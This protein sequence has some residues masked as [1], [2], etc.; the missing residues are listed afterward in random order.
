MSKRILSLMLVSLL[1]VGCS[2]KGGKVKLD[3]DGVAKVNGNPI[4]VSVYSGNSVENEVDGVKYTAKIITADNLSTAE[5]NSRGVATKDMDKYKDVLVF[6]EYLGSIITMYKD[7]GNKKYIWGTV[8]S[9]E[10]D[11]EVRKQT[12]YNTM[13]SSPLT[14]EKL[15]VDIG[16]K[17]KFKAAF[18]EQINVRANSVSI[19]KLIKITYGINPECVNAQN[20]KAGDKEISV[21]SYSDSKFTYYTYEGFTIQTVVGLDLKDYIEV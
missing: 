11:A 16:G 6:E 13:T 9:S 4:Q 17:F 12:L 19:P 1:L 10:G 5:G 8:M 18:D 15:V 3:N 2:N 14:D 20:I 21:M 7:L